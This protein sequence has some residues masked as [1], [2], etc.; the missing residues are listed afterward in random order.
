MPD[1]ENNLGGRM[2][3]KKEATRQNIIAAAV[4]LFQRDGYEPVTME[5]IAE[6]ADIAKGTLYNYYPVKEA[7]LGDY[8]DRES[9]LKNA[10]RIDRIRALP[11]TRSRLTVSLTELIAGIDQRKEIFERYFTYRIRQMLSLERDA[12]RAVGVHALESEIIRLGQAGGE[13]R[14]DLPMSLMEQLFEFIFIQLAQQYYNNPEK[15]DRDQAI[16]QSVDLFLNGTGT[17][18]SKS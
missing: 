4:R 17:P 3:R 15:F 14:V 11:D 7:I 2:D 18:G 5:Q 9:A 12:G 8:I 16:T 6:A 10:E 1:A 13:I